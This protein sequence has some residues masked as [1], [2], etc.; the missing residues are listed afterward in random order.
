MEMKET[1]QN[2]L[3]SVAKS[4][5]EL[6]KE[7]NL[8]NSILYGESRTQVIEKILP[9]PEVP[10]ISDIPE[11]NT[12]EADIPETEIETEN[13]RKGGDTEKEKFSEIENPETDNKSVQTDIGHM[14][15]QPAQ[16]EK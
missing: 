6:K 5:K 13:T 8:I 16:N 15:K 2:Q 4:K 9:V 1:V 7:E 10:G 3:A 11:Q 12:K 14:E